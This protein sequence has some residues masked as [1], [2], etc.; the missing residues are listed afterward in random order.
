ME[1]DSDLQDFIADCEWKT[2]KIL[3]E[4]NKRMKDS[5]RIELAKQRVEQLKHKGNSSKTPTLKSMATNSTS[6]KPL[7]QPS[8]GKTL[9]SN[10]V[11]TPTKQWKDKDKMRQSSAFPTQLLQQNNAIKQQSQ[12]QPPRTSQLQQT[13]HLFHAVQKRQHHQAAPKIMLQMAT[14][15]PMTPSMQWLLDVHL[16]ETFTS[17]QR[18]GTDHYRNQGNELTIRTQLLSSSRLYYGRNIDATTG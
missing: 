5:A 3:R 1:T 17:C 4:S 6:S 18:S 15:L 12:S 11:M 2:R 10:G 7:I 9:A 16:S 8:K 14:E 13:V